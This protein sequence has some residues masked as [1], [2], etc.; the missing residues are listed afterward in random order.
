MKTAYCFDL[1]G[2]L[3]TT[4]I[5][6]CIASELDVA[7]EIATLTRA[8]MDGLI[9]FEPSFRFRCLILGR[10]PAQRV[11]AIVGNVPLNDMVLQFIQRRKSD[12]FLVTGN[13]D[14]WVDPIV[15][16]C[17]CGAYTSQAHEDDGHLRLTSVLEK[18]HAIRDLRASGFDRIVAVGDGAND[19]AMLMAADVAIAYGGVHAPAPTATAVSRYVVHDGS[20]L[21]NLLQTL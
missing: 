4:E 21:C 14:I 13:L 11:R 9:A 6:P 15:Q 7:D 17:G 19:V 5:L 2:T 20:A 3:T 8:T 18:S 10:V 1:D 12:C 16:R